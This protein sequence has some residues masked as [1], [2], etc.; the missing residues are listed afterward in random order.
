[1]QQAQAYK[2]QG[3]HRTRLENNYTHLW[4][5]QARRRKEVK[6]TIFKMICTNENLKKG[7]ERKKKSASVNGGIPSSQGRPSYSKGAPCVPVSGVLLMEGLQVRVDV[8][9]ESNQLISVNILG[10]G[11]RWSG[12][13]YGCIQRR[14]L[15]SGHRILTTAVDPIVSRCIRLVSGRCASRSVIVLT[16]YASIRQ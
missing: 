9:A 10:D 8:V 6:E 13:T 11:L 14:K 4:Q 7:G 1:M 2:S 3:E 12:N 5:A 16:G 15:A